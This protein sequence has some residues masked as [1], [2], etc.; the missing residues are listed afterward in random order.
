MEHESK[1]VKLQISPNPQGPI[2][3]LVFLVLGALV[4]FLLA[5]AKNE[6][7]HKDDIPNTIS[8]SASARRSVKPDTAIASFS[9]RKENASLEIARNEVSTLST[10]VVDFLKREGVAEKDIKST[11]YN[12]YPQ[13]S[14][15]SR[16]CVLSSGTSI[17]CPP[18]PTAKTFVVETT[19]EVK[20]HDLDKVGSLIAGVS[21]SGVNQISSLRFT[22]DDVNMEKLRAEAR[23]EAIN[24]AQEKAKILARSLNVR[25]DGLVNFSEGGGEQPMYYDRSFGKGGMMEVASAPAPSIA[26]G[27]NEVVS[28]VTLV[29][30]ID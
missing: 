22:L 25:L 13:E 2:K 9:I 23:D 7:K 10:K 3:Y 30:E 21:E 24:K 18:R 27:E 17:A 12:I 4:L 28:S 15:D 11:S 1:E 5:G 6:L 8:T 16:P 19:Y 20:M 14:Y 29:Y 26:V